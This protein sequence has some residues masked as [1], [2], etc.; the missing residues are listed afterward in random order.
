MVSQANTQGRGKTKKSSNLLLICGQTCVSP[1]PLLTLKKRKGKGSNEATDGLSFGDKKRRFC[2][3]WRLSLMKGEKWHQQGRVLQLHSRDDSF[4]YLFI[5]SGIRGVMEIIYRLMWA[6]G[7]IKLNQKATTVAVSVW[8]TPGGTCQMCI[9]TF[10]ILVR[11]KA[12]QCR[13]PGVTRLWIQGPNFRGRF[14]L[15]PLPERPG[16]VLALIWEKPLAL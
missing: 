1:A 5:P 14:L 7:L 13:V 10:S 16:W 8:T 6:D 12:L 11:P 15:Q 9:L 4:F 3:Y 2:K